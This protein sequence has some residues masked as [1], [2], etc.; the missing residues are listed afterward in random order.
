M[1]DKKILLV[2]DDYTI[3]FFTRSIL[4]KKGFTNIK[5]VASGEDAV[6]A[7][8]TFKPDLILMD[9]TLDG[10]IDGISAAKKIQETAPIP[11]IYLTASSDRET[12][13]KSQETITRGF[14]RKPF[15]PRDIYACIENAFGIKLT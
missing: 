2:E 8:I 7:A 1:T 10:E 14:V 15:M 5:T 12:L 9:I 6:S 4:E 3:A 11:V 13:E